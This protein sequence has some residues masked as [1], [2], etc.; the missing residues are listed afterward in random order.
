MGRFHSVGPATNYDCAITRHLR[1]AR[2]LDMDYTG[3]EE[4]EATRRVA[5]QVGGNDIDLFTS[6]DFDAGDRA[7]I[8]SWA[9]PEA[10]SEESSLAGLPS[11]AMPVLT[12]A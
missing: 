12:L 7:V 3:P 1:N 5:I 2:L 11:G 9:I 10:D 4:L 8:S 6:I